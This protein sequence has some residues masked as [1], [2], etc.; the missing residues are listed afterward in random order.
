MKSQVFLTRIKRAKWPLAIIIVALLVIMSLRLFSPDTPTKV[1]EPQPVVITTLAIKKGDY[2]PSVLL[3]GTVDSAKEV[4]LKSQVAARVE[5]LPVEEGQSIKQGDV[6]VQLDPHDQKLAVAQNSARL[7]E[8]QALMK[9]GELNLNHERAT[10]TDQKALLDL[11]KASYE[12]IKKLFKEKIGGV[13]LNQLQSEEK[14]Y[15]QSKMAYAAQQKSIRQLQQQQRVLIH[16]VEQAQ[17]SLT[18]A[19]KRLKDCTVVAPFNGSVGTIHVA[20]HEEV[21]IGQPL[22][23][24]LPSGQVQMRALL[25][26]SVSDSVHQLMRRKAVIKAS[27]YTMLESMQP[28]SLTM[29][30]VSHTVKPGLVGREAIFKTNNPS[31]L[32]NGQHVNIKMQLPA[33]ENSFKVPLSGL[34]TD[35][36]LSGNSVTYIY[37]INA[38]RLQKVKV[39]TLGR[40]YSLNDATSV[41]V[42]PSKPA[43]LKSGDQVL[44]MQLPNAIDGLLVKPQAMSLRGGTNV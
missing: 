14:I 11:H 30:A 35:Y 28:I 21:T 22:V 2:H 43:Q 40:L 19:E 23:D 10:S 27:A 3:Y 15:L 42:Q 26:N 6:L 44:A 31:Q 32:A 5:R 4:T 34:Y 13:S 17:V 24:E 29:I 38:Q 20:Q 8:S 37:K 16:R 25:P 7:G 36:D 33:V 12:R 18:L 9:Q 1:D 39:T 41:L